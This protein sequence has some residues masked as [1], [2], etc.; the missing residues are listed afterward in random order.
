MRKN[1]TAVAIGAVL[2]LGA[3]AAAQAPAYTVRADNYIAHATWPSEGISKQAVKVT[4][5][6]L[7]GNVV[8]EVNGVT[9]HADR[10]VIKDGEVTFEGSVRMTLPQPK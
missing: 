3:F 5:R 9:V 4:H 7:T 1:V 2:G 6:T 10:A 8:L